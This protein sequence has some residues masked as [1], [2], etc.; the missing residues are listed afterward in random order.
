MSVLLKILSG[1]LCLCMRF[2]HLRIEKCKK[3]LAERVKRQ[4]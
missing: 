4:L 2:D 1:L 3:E